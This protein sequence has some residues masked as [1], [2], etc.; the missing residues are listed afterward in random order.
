[1]PKPA[2]VRLPDEQTWRFRGIEPHRSVALERVGPPSALID[3]LVQ[4]LRATLVSDNA[5]VGWEQKEHRPGDCRVVIQFPVEQVLLDWFSNGWSGYRAH[6]RA[7][8]RCGLQFNAEIITAMAS[9]L[10]SHLGESV[11]GHLLDWH[12]N[13]VEARRIRRSDILRSLAPDLAKI[14][15]SGQLIGSSNPLPTGMGS[16]SLDIEGLSQRWYD[17]Y[18]DAGDAW[19]ELK[20]AYIGAAGPY[21]W[22]NPKRRAICL[23]RTGLM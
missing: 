1:V 2:D 6:Y 23:H 21:Q 14:W 18:R 13:V 12:F 16:R 22:K 7:D 8:P 4:A 5:N 17:F 20:G 9:L 10:A 11:P 19:L 15:L 3:A